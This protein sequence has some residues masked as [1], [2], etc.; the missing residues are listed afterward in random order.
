MNNREG[1]VTGM[2]N[3]GRRKFP[4]IKWRDVAGPAAPY[5]AVARDHDLYVWVAAA[6]AEAAAATHTYGTRAGCRASARCFGH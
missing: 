2:H 3:Q 4:C 1:K 6:P 5:G